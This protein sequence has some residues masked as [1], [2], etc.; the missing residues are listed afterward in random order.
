M[1]ACDDDGFVVSASR[2]LADAVTLDDSALL[3]LCANLAQPY[4]Y[5]FLVLPALY[6]GM[7]PIVWNLVSLAELAQ[8]CTGLNALCPLAR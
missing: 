8:D 6:E 2:R 7:F 1:D 3:L 4:P 5:I